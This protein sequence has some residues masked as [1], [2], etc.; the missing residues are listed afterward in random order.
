MKGLWGEIGVEHRC[1]QCEVVIS[2]ASEDSE[3]LTTSSH[4]YYT[5]LSPRDIVFSKGGWVGPKKNRGAVG[6]VANQS[7]VFQIWT[8][9]KAVFG[10]RDRL[11]RDGIFGDWD[12]VW[13]ESRAVHLA[14]RLS[15]NDVSGNDVSGKVHFT[16]VLHRMSLILGSCHV[17][18]PIWD[19]GR[20]VRMRSGKNANLMGNN[21]GQVLTG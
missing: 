15:G 9:Q 18:L 17:D 8:N 2:Y 20:R 19:V 7:A 6:E 16:G 14:T 13:V 5:T 1:H 10:S 21:D 12:R 3:T 11:D 4:V